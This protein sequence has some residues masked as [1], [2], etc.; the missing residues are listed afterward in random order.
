MAVVHAAD[1]DRTLPRPVPDAIAPGEE[2]VWDYPRPPIARFSDE[3]IVIVLGG[4]EI[5]ESRASWRVLETAHP[6]TYY[7]PRSAFRPGSLISA[8]G[9]SFCEWKGSASY[10][11]V[12][13]GERLARKAA[14]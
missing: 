2:S 14:W 9:D 5:C 3:E 13:G 11:D 1:D 8:R 10:L 12:Y 7:L 6:P 4:E